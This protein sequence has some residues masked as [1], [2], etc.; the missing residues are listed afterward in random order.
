MKNTKSFIH[1]T[2][3][4]FTNS[5]FTNRKFTNLTNL[6][7]VPTNPNL[8]K[9]KKLIFNFVTLN[10][11]MFVISI[12]STGCAQSPSSPTIDN[13]QQVQNQGQQPSISLAQT[14]EAS[15]TT[16]DMRTPSAENQ[17]QKMPTQTPPVGSI[18]ATPEKPTVKERASGK[19]ETA[20]Q[21]IKG[22]TVLEE[23]AAGTY[24]HILAEGFDPK[25]S[26]NLSLYD[27]SDCKVAQLGKT[28]T[29]RPQK[30]L[31]KLPMSKKGNI[32]FTQFFEGVK[33]KGESGIT[34]S[35]III[36]ENTNQSTSITNQNTR[37]SAA[38]VV[39]NK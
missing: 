31:A 6:K 3:T 20:N 17:M 32:K 4:K 5:K 7:K 11:L 36:T 28:P 24:I 8:E 22:T 33:V 15:Q 38:C 35:S 1:A 21:S 2:K 16:E 18:Q 10:A 19:I 23:T 30:V 13:K 25:S 14:A 26:Y 27:K 9:A 12:I 34:N 29:S 37:T 39:L